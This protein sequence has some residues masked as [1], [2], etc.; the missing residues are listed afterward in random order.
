MNDDLASRLRDLGRRPVPPATSTAH[1]T[2]M[3]AVSSVRGPVPRRFG[4]VA[5]GLAAI[6]GFLVG[7]SGL[8]MAGALPA[9]VQEGVA[10]VLAQVGLDVP[11]GGYRNRGA[12]VSAIARSQGDDGVEGAAPE[13]EAAAQ[14]ERD[15]VKAAKEQCP[16]GGRSGQTGKPDGQCKGK[17]AADDGTCTR[18]RSDEVPAPNVGGSPDVDG[19][20]EGPCDGP[21]PW[22]GG[23]MDKAAKR[24]AQ[25][26]RAALCPDDEAGAVEELDEPEDDADKREDEAAELED[27]AADPAG[28]D[29][30][31][32]T[33]ELKGDEREGN[34]KGTEGDGLEGDLGEAP[35]PA[36]RGSTEPADDQAEAE[37][38][39]EGTRTWGDVD[40]GGENEHGSW[41][42]GHDGGDPSGNKA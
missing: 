16:K 12:C 40:G 17:P 2:A 35:A 42:R 1:L 13:D 7:G 32:G 4:G 5:V 8:A 20:L 33:D 23:G 25:D 38:D 37:P 21:P 29:A 27:E 26:A 18:G 31:D 6:T 10:G 28:L 19:S 34:G 15:R 14:A 39:V 11:D 30:D 36:G 3:S 41:S 24:A 9:P 22:A